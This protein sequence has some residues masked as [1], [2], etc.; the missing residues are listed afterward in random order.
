[1]STMERI[2]ECDRLIGLVR[3]EKE[4]LMDAMQGKPEPHFHV[5]DNRE[6]ERRYRFAFR[7]ERERLQERRMEHQ[8][9]RTLMVR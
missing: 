6:Q 7:C 9:Q 2:A 3:A 4:G 1:M 8:I 5:F